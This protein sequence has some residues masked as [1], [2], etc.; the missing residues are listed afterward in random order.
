MRFTA[1]AVQLSLHVQTVHSCV[2]RVGVLWITSFV[3]YSIHVHMGVLPN[4]N[5][6]VIFG[7]IQM[8]DYTECCVM[9]DTHGHVTFVYYKGAV[10][11][12]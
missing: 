2:H 10:V 8:K 9:V 5:V 6:W 3:I 12:V 7:C 11:W 1:H 4:C